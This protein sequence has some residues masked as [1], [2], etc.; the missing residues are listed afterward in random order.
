LDQSTSRLTDID[1]V[2]CISSSLRFYAMAEQPEKG[3]RSQKEPPACPKC[4]ASMDPAPYVPGLGMFA[5]RIFEC[6]E[7]GHVHVIPDA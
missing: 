6:R 1:P 7:C 5:E 3:G 2:D 4:Q